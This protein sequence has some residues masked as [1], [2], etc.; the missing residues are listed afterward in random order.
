VMAAEIPRPCHGIAPPR[1]MA[2]K[3]SMTGAMG[4]K[5]NQNAYFPEPCWLGR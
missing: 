1:K 5:F 2:R 4:L 3:H